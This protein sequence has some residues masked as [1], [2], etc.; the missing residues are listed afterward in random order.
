MI[1]FSSSSAAAASSSLWWLSSRLSTW[2]SHSCR[3]LPLLSVLSPCQKWFRM[4]AGV[5]ACHPNIFMETSQ[6]SKTASDKWHPWSSR[7]QVAL[8][9]P[10]HSCEWA[11]TRSSHT[12]RLLA[13]SDVSGHGPS[14]ARTLRSDSRKN[15]TNSPSPSGP[16]AQWQLGPSEM[17]K[18]CWP[19]TWAG[20]WLGHPSEK[21]DFVNW[22]D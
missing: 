15:S 11:G 9:S 4:R 13:N 14:H 3:F 19:A 16:K 8:P 5:C 18:E 12:Q 21:Y 1:S 20:W 6:Q 2:L 17:L 10:M 22:D 7:L